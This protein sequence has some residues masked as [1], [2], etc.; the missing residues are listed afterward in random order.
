M[1]WVL[2]DSDGDHRPA[3][4]AERSSLRLAVLDGVAEVLEEND[5]LRRLEE[6]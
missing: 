5:L 4:I 6:G 3:D 1:Q 2:D